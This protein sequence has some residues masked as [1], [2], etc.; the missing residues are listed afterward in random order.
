[1]RQSQLRR[2]PISSPFWT[3]CL[4]ACGVAS[5][6][7][8]TFSLVEPHFF[9]AGVAAAVLLFGAL[10]IV[11]GR[12]AHREMRTAT[13][14]ALRDPLTGLP[15]R[16]LFDD[17]IMRAVATSSR[18]G[19]GVALLVMDVDR[20]KEVNDTFGHAAGDVLLQEVACRVVAAVREV[21]TVARIGGDEFAVVL[22]GAD[23]AVARETVHRIRA[24]L[25]VPLEI[26]GGRVPTSAS[27]GVSLHPRD[28]DT[29]AA[30]TEHADTAMYTAKRAGSGFAFYDVSV[31]ATAAARRALTEELG[32]AIG[33]D[34]LVLHYQPRLDLASGRLTSVEALLRWRHPSRGLLSADAFV[35]DAARYGLGGAIFE[36]ALVAAF[37][38]A[39]E[40]QKNRLDV[41]IS[42]NVDP[43]T[44]EGRLPA[45]IA[46]LLDEHEVDAERIEIDIPE[47]A[48]VSD[49]ARA[50]R[51][52]NELA[53][54]GL[55]LVIDDFGTGRHASLAALGVFP[56]EKVK[57]GRSFLHAA[58]TS[59]RE[60]AIAHATIGLAHRLSLDVVAEGVEDAE[61][62]AFARDLEA[63]HAQ[64][65]FVGHPVDASSVATLFAEPAEAVA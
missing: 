63:D 59:P 17:R 42:V 30:L 1:L 16:R 57:L 21:D 51:V 39:G 12:R 18:T 33:A 58:R 14:D 50:R 27:I 29:P 56:L 28:G 52:A 44:L 32:A 36:H 45:M 6:A 31:R 20:F 7:L 53:A 43:R 9:A 61:S 25:D 23:E 19:E 38:Q 13:L 37:A 65:Y 64:G 40:W 47:D 11:L 48:I 26:G 41:G 35:A 8:G 62:L 54:L 5:A 60:R 55:V 46:R 10:I 24:A 22:V 49:F 2:Y 34:Q 15:T 3:R 4:L